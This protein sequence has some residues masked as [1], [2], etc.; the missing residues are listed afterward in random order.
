MTVINKAFLKFALLP[1]AMYRRMGVNTVQL[2]S[3][4]QAKLTIDDR[5]PNAMQQTSYRKKDKPVTAA[6]IGTMIMSALIGLIY[7]VAFGIGND[8]I[9]HLTVYFTFFFFMLSATL[10]SDFTSVLIDVRDNYIILPKPVNDRTF[11]AARL[12]HIFI[13]ICKLVLP[14]SIGGI[15]YMTNETGLAGVLVFL[16]MLL[17]ATVFSIFFINAVYILILRITT[18]GRFQSIISYVQIFLAIAMYASY[19]I[20]PSLMG[21]AELEDFNVQAYRWVVLYPVYWLAACWK[22]VSTASGSTGEIIA[23]AAGLLLP[24]LSLWLVFRYLAPSF[25]NRLALTASGTLEKPKKAGVQVVRKDSS[26]GRFLAGLFTRSTAERMGFLFVWKMTGR[27]R[28]FKL[29]VYPAIGYMAVY[30]V[31]ILMRSRNINLDDI[32][33][34]G[35]SGR[36]LVISALYFTS[37]IFIMASNQVIYSDKYKAAWIFY[38]SPLRAP[39]E[40]IIGGA[41]A[42]TMKFFLPIAVF[43][44]AGSLAMGAWKLMP[45]IILGLFNQLLIVTLTVYISKRVFPFSMHQNAGNR[46]G[47]FIRNLGVMAF[48]GLLALGHFFIFNMLYVVIIFAVLSIAAT[49]L[50]MSGIR[51]SSWETVKEMSSE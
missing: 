9:T 49:W 1:S 2:R 50:L 21:D 14:M 42:A 51:S 7:L 27:S 36:G 3:I 16:V 44:V 25:N 37:L 19:Q 32:R 38:I 11:M 24:F 5:R 30:V 28:D 26:Y 6:T 20:L 46:G 18:P 45:N 17:F 41:K 35:N 23:A 40:V 4:L 12:L 13:H 39:G 15:V 33:E 10:I 8:M 47:S 43:I 22:V 48:L 29:K 34:A 31:V